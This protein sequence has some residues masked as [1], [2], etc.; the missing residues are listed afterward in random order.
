MTPEEERAAVV[1]ESCE[2]R[3]FFLKAE[4]GHIYGDCHHL[5]PQFNFYAN[6][7]EK[8]DYTQ[9]RHRIDITRERGGCWPNISQDDWCGEYLHLSYGEPG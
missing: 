7:Y 1:R 6:I 5:P 8:D 9:K 4:P 2:T 3:R